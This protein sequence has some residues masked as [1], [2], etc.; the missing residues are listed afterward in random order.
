MVTFQCIQIFR[1][2]FHHE[3]IRRLGPAQILGIDPACA[4]TQE[5]QL[6]QSREV[7]GVLLNGLFLAADRLEK[8][9]GNINRGVV[10]GQGGWPSGR[11]RAFSDRAAACLPEM[12]AD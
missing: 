5:G 8:L 7:G 1:S 11:P 10:V 3:S 12:P 9:S 2:L 6:F 4:V